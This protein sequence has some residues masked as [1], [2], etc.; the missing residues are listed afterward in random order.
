M[1]VSMKLVISSVEADDGQALVSL[2]RWLSRDSAVAG[3]GRVT[4]ETVSGQLGDMG[5]AV[6]VITMVFADAGAVA[7][8]GS[9]L[10]AYCTWRSTRTQAPAFKIE[11]DGVTVVVEQGS[12]QEVRRVLE[13]MLPGN[14]TEGASGAAGEELGGR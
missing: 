14:D 8:I 3:R 1:A 5:G 11:K 12:E 7:G 13:V 2:Y 9:M 10:V 4:V 6:D